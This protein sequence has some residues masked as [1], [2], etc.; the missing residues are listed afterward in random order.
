MISFTLKV[1]CG[2]SIKYELKKNE[3]EN[4]GV[5]I[6]VIIFQVRVDEGVLHCGSNGRGQRKHD[7]QRCVATFGSAHL[8]THSRLPTQVLGL[9][10]CLFSK[11]KQ[12][13]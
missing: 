5:F 2:N 9:P 11:L 12:G 3:C 10:T 7:A 13:K 8:C 6:I 1:Y 4:K